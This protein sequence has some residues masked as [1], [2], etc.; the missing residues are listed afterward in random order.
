MNKEEDE[1]EKNKPHYKRKQKDFNHDIDKDAASDAMNAMMA[2]SIAST[3]VRKAYLKICEIAD[4]PVIVTKKELMEGIVR[5]FRICKQE[6]VH[7]TASLEPENPAHRQ[8]GFATRTHYP[9]PFVRRY[10]NNALTDLKKKMHPKLW[11]FE[12][13][14]V[15][16]LSGQLIGDHGM[17]ELCENLAQS[18]VEKI[19]LNYNNIT[20]KGLIEFSLKL[21]SL[22]NLRELYLAGNKFRDDGIEALFH[23][24]RYSPTLRLI[25]L[26]ENNLSNRSAWAIGMMFYP[27]RECQF[28]E[29]IIG[30]QHTIRYSLDKFLRALVPHLI[31]PGNR[32]LKKLH[33][34]HAGLTDSG[35]LAIISLLL[36]KLD[37]AED[38]AAGRHKDILR[39]GGVEYLVMSRSPIFK[40]PHRV[41]FLNALVVM[42]YL[43]LKNCVRCQ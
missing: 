31:L 24:E 7:K 20:N 12:L 37:K 15:I 38:V 11:T 10:S 19:A 29:L 9:S 13:C 16:D 4:T 6:V 18:P 36:G 21:R 2:C 43:L 1:E 33:V 42:Y 28:E 27:S 40:S 25:N 8:N 17:M 5:D 3:S 30:G 22:S 26:S 41:A 32:C 35:I 23:G 39:G 34:G 14:R